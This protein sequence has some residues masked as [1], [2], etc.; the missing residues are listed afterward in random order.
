MFLYALAISAMHRD[1]SGIRVENNVA[2]WRIDKHK[3]AK[4]V[5]LLVAHREWPSHDG[6]H[7]HSANAVSLADR[8]FPRS[9]HR[10]RL[11]VASGVA[12]HRLHL[13][14]EG[15]SVRGHTVIVA[16]A[17]DFESACNGFGAMLFE[18]YPII[19]GWHRHNLCV[20]EVTPAATRHIHPHLLC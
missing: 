1:A 5:G 15:T 11:F 9:G 7:E 19:C 13:D 17:T 6:W 20:V 3:Y 14:G 16:D 18:E 10:P 2:L 12:L 4:R 8:R